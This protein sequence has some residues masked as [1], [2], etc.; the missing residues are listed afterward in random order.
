MDCRRRSR[1]RTEVSGTAPKSQKALR[2]RRVLGTGPIGPY[3]IQAAIAAVHD[4][5][6]RAQDTDWPQILALYEVLEQVAPSP[7]VTLNRAVALAQV[8]GPRPGL[9]VLGRLKRMNA[10]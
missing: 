4:E 1:S 2:F 9:A 7:I 8:H 3:Q 5:A 10:W 6:P